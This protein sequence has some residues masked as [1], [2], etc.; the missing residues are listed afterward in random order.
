MTLTI[1]VVVLT[2]V[3]NQTNLTPKVTLFV[4]PSMAIC[5][6]DKT[7]YLAQHRVHAIACLQVETVQ[8]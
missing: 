7:D 8:P 3:F 5:E 1:M 4:K 2:S 6:Q